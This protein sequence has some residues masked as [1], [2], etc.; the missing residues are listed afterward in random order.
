MFTVHLESSSAYRKLMESSTTFPLPTTPLLPH[1]HISTEA[2]FLPRRFCL[3]ATGD[4]DQP[5]LDTS[6]R[7]ERLYL[8]PLEKRKFGRGVFFKRLSPVSS[9]LWVFLTSILFN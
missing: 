7:K 8:S 5:C 3:D 2:P 1:G 6:K 9:Q 4:L